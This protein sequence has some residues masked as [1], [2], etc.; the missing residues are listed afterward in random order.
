MSRNKHGWSKKVAKHN[1]QAAFLLIAAH[2]LI[3]SSASCLVVR[4]G[5]GHATRR[6]VNRLL[7]S[8]PLSILPSS[9]SVIPFSFTLLMYS[10]T[11]PSNINT[12]PVPSRAP[13]PHLLYLYTIDFPFSIHSINHVDLKA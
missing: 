12:S 9:L 11:G 4:D 6:E 7:P 13:V 5:D 1:V 8:C 3:L 2:V 10:L